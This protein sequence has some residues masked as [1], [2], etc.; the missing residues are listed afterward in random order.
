MSILNRLS[1]DVIAATKTVWADQ[2]IAEKIASDTLEIIA[3]ANKR[4]FTFFSG[5]SSRGLIGGLFYIL[6][7]KYDSVKRQ[8][9]LANKLGTTDITIRASYRKWLK[10]FPDLF[11]NVSDKIANREN[12]NHFVHSIGDEGELLKVD[13][14]LDLDDFERLLLHAIDETIRNCLGNINAQLIYSYLDKKECPMQ[15]IPKK[16]DVFVIELENLMGAG[17][18]RKMDA[19][20]ILKKEI[21]EA[22]CAKLGIDYEVD[23]N[24]MTEQIKKLRKLHSKKTSDLYNST[25]KQKLRSKP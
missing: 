10:D 19:A 18:G 5:K 15:E 20:Q 16:I 11:L 6:G 2:L 9:E 21:L 14:C 7:F 17:K 23:P 25:I 13:T 22:F 12:F 24:C 3:N 8:K 4:N 1:A